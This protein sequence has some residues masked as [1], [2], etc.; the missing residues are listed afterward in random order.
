MQ[1]AQRV[2]ARGR[3]AV[4][5]LLS[6]RRPAPVQADRLQQT[7][8]RADAVQN[9]RDTRGALRKINPA[10]L[11]RARIA[12]VKHCR[13][14]SSCNLGAAPPN[15]HA[16]R[17]QHIQDAAVIGLMTLRTSVTLVAG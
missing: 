4:W 8:L 12:E 6:I 17:R 2:I 7:D 16:R 3:N 11:S 1:G 9:E 10:E 13:L 5:F 15:R 14:P